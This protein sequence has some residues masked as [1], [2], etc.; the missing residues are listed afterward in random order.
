LADIDF[1]NGL[2]RGPIP[3]KG[4]SEALANRVTPASVADKLAPRDGR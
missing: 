2:L 3:K 4:R 1:F